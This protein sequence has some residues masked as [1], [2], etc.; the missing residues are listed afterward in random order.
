M[1]L[2]TFWIN[3]I[4]QLWRQRSVLWLSGVR[5]TGKTILCQSLDEIEYFDC[6]LPRIRRQIEIEPESFI[7][8]LKGKRVA[9]DEIHRLRNPSEVLKIAA[10]HYTDVKI[11]ATGSSTL[12]ASAKFRDTLTGRKSEIWLTPMMSKDMQDF[13]NESLPHRLHFGGLPP[14]FLSKQMLER[15]FQEWID[16]YW[17]KDI[18]ELFRLEKHYSFTKF[19]ELIFINS[20]GIFEATKYAAPC[21]ISRTSVSNYLNVLGKTWVAHIIRPYSER[22]A[23]EIVSAPKVY[24]FDTGFVCYFRGWYQLREEDM[25]YLWEH[26]VLNEIQSHFPDV[27]IHYW[28]NKQGNEV[29]FIL[30]KRGKPPIA[31]ECKWKANNIHTKNIKAFRKLHVGDENF[32][33]VSDIERPVTHTFDKLKINLLKLRDLIEHLSK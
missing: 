14:F 31:I 29:D 18:Q 24:A 23:N 28:R 7:S 11:I 16:S 9:L 1:K 30:L 27:Q 33:V 13:E 20:G 26:Y 21:E 22:L 17:A 5:R 19:L 3:K 6:E 2:R 4:E 12:Q 32:V 25:G 15:D 8:S 10:D